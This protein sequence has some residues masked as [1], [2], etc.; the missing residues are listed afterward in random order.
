[1]IA[2][3]DSASFFRLYHAFVLNIRIIINVFS[4]LC[5]NLLSCIRCVLLVADSSDCVFN[6][7]LPLL[8]MCLFEIDSDVVVVAVG[9][10]VAVDFDVYVDVGGGVNVYMLC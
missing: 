7:L 8:L 1:M 3:A 10:D 6:V 5:L 4:S 9:V 2:L